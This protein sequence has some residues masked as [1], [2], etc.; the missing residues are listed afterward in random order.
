M[1]LA[2]QRMYVH[3][4]GAAA[5]AGTRRAT[6][7]SRCSPSASPTWASIWGP[8]RTSRARRRSPSGSGEELDE[9]V[10]A[11]ELHDVGKIAIPDA[12]LHKPGPLD[13]DEWAFMRQHTVIGERILAPRP[14]CARSPARARQPRALGRHRLPRRPRGRGDPARRPDRR[15]RARLDPRGHDPRVVATLSAASYVQLSWRWTCAICFLPWGLR[16]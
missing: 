8:S 14:R 1:R 11:A 6:C 16:A 10:R 7:S 13:D 15:R 9:V 12:I 2:D 5:P 4:D 3:K